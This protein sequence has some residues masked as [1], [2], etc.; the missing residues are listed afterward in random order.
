MIE[1]VLLEIIYLL[2]F[3]L[4]VETII[5]FALII[6]VIILSKYTIKNTSVLCRSDVFFTYTMATT[7]MVTYFLLVSYTNNLSLSIFL[8]VN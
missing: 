1:D 8:K 4:V 7:F 5:V 2:L 6:F 3:V